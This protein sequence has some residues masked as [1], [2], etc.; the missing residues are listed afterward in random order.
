VDLLFSA[1]S[2]VKALFQRIG[3]L[4]MQLRGVQVTTITTAATVD[5][6]PHATVKAVKWLVYLFEEATPANAQALEVFATTNGT[7]VDDTQYAKIKVG[8]NFNYTVTVD[9]SG[10]DMRLRIASTT[11]GVTATVRRIE[12]VKTVL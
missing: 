5:S 11:A 10:A 2:T 4:L 3:D 6:V 12:V 9:I 1:T 7:N 8:A